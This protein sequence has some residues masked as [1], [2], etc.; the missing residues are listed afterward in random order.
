MKWCGEQ[1]FGLGLKTFLERVSIIH[2]AS[3]PLIPHI[4]IFPFLSLTRPF[5]SPYPS[6][7]LNDCSSCHIGI[8]TLLKIG[9][10]VAANWNIVTANSNIR[11]TPFAVDNGSVHKTDEDLERYDHTCVSFLTLSL[12]KACE[13]DTQ[14]VRHV[15]AIGH[16][17]R[18]FKPSRVRWI[19]KSDKTVAQLPSERK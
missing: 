15:C 11:H 17:V 12:R 16:K 18:G 13:V 4:S 1:N 7:C 9:G 8:C 2:F 3:Y 19:F 14:L 5:S 10:R 6:P